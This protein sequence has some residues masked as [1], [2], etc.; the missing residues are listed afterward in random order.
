MKWIEKEQSSFQHSFDFRSVHD[1]GTSY[2]HPFKDF[3]TSKA[4][5]STKMGPNL[6][7]LNYELFRPPKISSIHHH[8]QYP[9]DLYLDHQVKVS[10]KKSLWAFLAPG[11][12]H[13]KTP[14]YNKRNMWG[15]EAC[16]KFYVA[17]TVLAFEHLHGRK[18]LGT[19]IG[20]YRM[21]MEKKTGGRYP[22]TSPKFSQRTEFLHKLLVKHPGAHL[23]NGFCGWDLRIGGPFQ[24]KK[25]DVSFRRFVEDGAF[26][27]LIGLIFGCLKRPTNQQRSNSPHFTVIWTKHC[28]ECYF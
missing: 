8:V 27:Q 28:R 26:W 3:L 5:I 15:N 12:Q 14:R 23:P 16:A 25:L 19:F 13:P 11:K 4:P 22:Q 6:V 10:K 24:I 20:P 18:L 17:G 2:I 21:E 7:L 9:I 1:S